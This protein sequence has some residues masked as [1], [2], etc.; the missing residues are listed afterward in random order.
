MAG[1]LGMATRRSRDLV[2]RVK[3]VANDARHVA[4]QRTLGEADP[5]CP[6][7]FGSVK[8]RLERNDGQVGDFFVGSWSI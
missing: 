3:D 5:N 1:E 7:S 2:S 6:R 8:E 4:G